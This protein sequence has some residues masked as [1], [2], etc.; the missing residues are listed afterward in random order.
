MET[1]HLSAVA[2]ALLDRRLAGER[3]D[4]T[5]ETRPAYQELVAAGLM[6]PLHTLTGGSNSAFRFTEAACDLRDGLNSQAIHVPSDV[7]APALGG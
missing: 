2:S 1:I 5:D 3:V 7:E 6:I 4:V